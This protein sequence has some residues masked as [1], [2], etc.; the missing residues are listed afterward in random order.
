MDTDVLRN[1]TLAV[2]AAALV[3][4]VTTRRLLGRAIARSEVATAVLV[5]G[6]VWLGVLAVEQLTHWWR[7]THG[8]T[9][10]LG[11]PLETSLGWA[12]MWGAL[13]V[14]AGGRLVLWWLGTAWADVLV[15]PALDPLLVLGPSWWW[16]EA[17]LL[18]G[19][20]APALLLGHATRTR[21]WLPLRALL[22]VALAAGLLLWIVP[23]T[24]FLHGAGGWD[25]VADLPLVL[26]S[27]L[28][29]AVVAV[30]VPALSAVQELA[31]AGGTP[32]PWDP[33]ERLVT[34]GPYAYLRNPMQL[35][36][37]VVLALLGGASGSAL[38]TGTA[39]V[40]V[41]FSLALAER[42]ET[43]AMGRRWPEHAEY[44]RHV[45][46][47]LPRL[48]PHVPVPSELWVSEEC[49]LCR[50]AGTAL[51]VVRP[52]GLTILAAEDAGVRLTRMRW[53][54][55]TGADRGVAAFGRALEQV[56]LGA[57]WFGWLVRLPV[58]RTVAQV[59]ADG[60]GLG[61]REVPAGR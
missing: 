17:L 9:D 35:G 31:R 22:Q 61:P 11:M 21:T 1:L 28:L 34:T 46:A 2:P 14:L 47:W 43:A 12:V 8:P 50:T 37:S 32:W 55:P 57:A 45:R 44:R 48:R 56:H 4:A 41:V 24:A 38:L 52:V 54:G 3:G 13:P 42:H 23:E 60:C 6:L 19:V 51:A 36:A 59:V 29:T 16:G 25:R 39:L 26:R 7:F 49:G 40:T 27:L 53:V 5:S 20:L 33:P 15:M 30:G 58:V 18:L 10:F